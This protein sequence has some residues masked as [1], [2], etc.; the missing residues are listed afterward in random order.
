MW[1]DLTFEQWNL[2]CRGA[3]DETFK[4]KSCEDLLY[5]VTCPYRLHAMKAYGGVEVL[6][7]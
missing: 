5:N 7:H 2:N 1:N 4:S 6:R 3:E